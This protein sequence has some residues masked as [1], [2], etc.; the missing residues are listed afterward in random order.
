[1]TR[2]APLALIALAACQ[3]PSTN[4]AAVSEEQKQLDAPVKDID[5]I[6]VDENAA[7]AVG[8]GDDAP[9]KR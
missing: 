7:A 3:Q 6:P 5:D 2:F 1:M 8:E 4:D 9:P